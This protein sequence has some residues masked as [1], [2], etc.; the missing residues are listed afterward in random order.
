MT[1]AFFD[2]SAR[3]RRG[4]DDK[5]PSRVDRDQLKWLEP[6]LERA[7]TDEFPKVV[8]NLFP[9]VAIDKTGDPQ[10]STDL[11][12]VS[13][14][15]STAL[16]AVSGDV[17]LLDKDRVRR[18]PPF[19][20][21]GG[22]CR[23]LGSGV[24]SPRARRLPGFSPGFERRELEKCPILTAHRPR[25]PGQDRTLF[26]RNCPIVTALWLGNPGQDR[27]LL[28]RNC[29]ILTAFSSAADACSCA[30]GELA[31]AISG[32]APAGGA[33]RGGVREAHASLAWRRSRTVQTF[34]FRRPPAPLTSSRQPDAISALRARR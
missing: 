16:A 23:F 11:V 30:C 24:P 34:V 32:R 31:D 14:D 21:V 15:R 5:R 19:R 20:G 25:H 27:T 18:A 10:A 9:V 7:V 29:P 1:E 13:T 17:R 12:E 22:V 6:D 4:R 26:G 33:T 28:G 2:P 3:G 8:S